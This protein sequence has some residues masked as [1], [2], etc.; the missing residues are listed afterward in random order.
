SVLQP[1]FAGA[2]LL[3]RAALPVLREEATMKRGRAKWGWRR[4][5]VWLWAA[6]AA[7]S[8]WAA[9]TAPESAVRAAMLFN[10]LKFTD[11][12]TLRE[13]GRLEICTASNDPEQSAAIEALAGRQVRGRT[14]V[15]Q[16]FAPHAECDVIFVDSRRSWSVVV[17]RGGMGRALT[18]G[19][20]TGFVAEG[21]II[22][23]VL[24]EDR[25]RFDINL[26]EARRIGV[27]FSPQL[28]QLARRVIE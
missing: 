14:L 7:A 15:V 12:P 10:F 11:W 28:L 8:A 13:T 4:L 23:I 5:G 3:R 26:S 25:T 18:V 16:R 22:E 20:F 21:G 1:A 6:L 27:R 2:Q 19:S 24:Q 17:E 9:E